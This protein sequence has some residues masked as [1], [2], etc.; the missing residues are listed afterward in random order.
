VPGR[1]DTFFV[2]FAGYGEQ[3]VFAREIDLAAR[4]VAD[5]FGARDRSLRLVNDRRDVE[6]WPLASE[7]ALR[8]ALRR[9][10]GMMGEEDVL[11]LALSSHG[12]RDAALKVTNPGMM[13]TRLRAEALA[14]MLRESGIAWR[15]VVVSACYSGSFVDALADERTVVIA[16]AAADRKSFGCNDRRELTHF[17]E[18]FFRDALPRAQSLRSAFDTARAEIVRRENRQGLVPSLPQAHFGEKWGQSLFPRN[19]P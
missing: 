15:V 17:G 9:L 14:Q 1:A 6:T 3:Q 19:G 16:A 8:H 13:P 2:G 12:E 11:F 4:V 18:A 7:P 10:G 5:V